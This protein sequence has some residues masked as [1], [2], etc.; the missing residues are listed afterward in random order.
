VRGG[1]ASL[2]DR[3][4]GG[5]RGQDRPAHK[6]G[7]RRIVAR[8]LRRVEVAARQG[9]PNPNPSS[10]PNPSPNPNPNPNPNL[11][12]NPNPNPYPNPNLH[13]QP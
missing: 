3:G 12:P 11:T 2:P 10:N 13:L 9:N 8:G 6:A 1:E 5:R 7:P 4:G